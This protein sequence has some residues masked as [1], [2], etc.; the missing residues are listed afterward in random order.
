M[1]DWYKDLVTDFG[2]DANSFPVPDFSEDCLYLNIWTLQASK[3]ANL[4]VMVW[5]HGGAHRGGW[6][7]EPN[8]I[9]DMLARQGVVVV[10]IAYRLD[11]FGFFSHPELEV[12][13]FGLLDQIAALQWV[14]QN[15]TAFGG[16]KNNVTV[17]GESAGAASIGFLLASALAKGLFHRA[18]HQSAGYEFVNFDNR[19]DFMEQGVAL[20]RQVL[21]TKSGIDALRKAPASQLIG[22]ADNIY[23][24]YRPGVVMDGKTVAEA[25]GRSLDK[26]QLQSVDLLIGSNADEWLMYL[27]PDA[28]EADLLELLEEYEVA[29]QEAV[30]AELRRDANIFRQMDR[31]ITAEEF[32]CPSLRLAEAAHSNHKNAFV[33]Y[34]DRVRPGA[35]GATVGAYHGAEIPYVF[36]KHDKWLPTADLD[37]DIGQQMMR[38]WVSFARTGNPNAEGLPQWPS[39]AEGDAGVLQIGDTIRSARHPEATLCELIDSGN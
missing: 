2:G 6:S 7:Y 16:D 1:V 30:M 28:D 12:S 26:G 9:G 5:I 8:Y 3:D 4:P 21:R 18:T 17:F 38:Y 23:S 32:V 15:V 33:Y 27:D 24:E 34:F 39:Y 31:L 25:P 19:N 13:N 22:A 35:K 20:E 10:S 37:R 36:N 14:Q 11:V 29:N